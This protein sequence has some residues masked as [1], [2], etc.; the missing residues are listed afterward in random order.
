MIPTTS[1]SKQSGAPMGD[2]HHING[3]SPLAPVASCPASSSGHCVDARP[4]INISISEFSDFW[5]SPQPEGQKSQSGHDHA[6]IRA[7]FGSVRRGV[8]TLQFVQI[9][10]MR[11]RRIVMRNLSERSLRGMLAVLFVVTVGFSIACASAPVPVMQSAS[12]RTFVEPSLQP[13]AV[14]SIAIFPMRNVRLQPD[15][16]REI[17]R[18]I[19]EGFRKQNPQLKIVGATESVTMLNDGGL[20]EKYSE[21]LRNYSQSSIPDV[22]ILQEIGRSLGVNAILQ[23]EVFSV[24][25]MDA[26]SKMYYGKTSLQMRYI[27]LSTSNGSILWDSSSSAFKLSE[28]GQP[29]PAI[30]EVIQMGQEKIL[31]SLPTLAQ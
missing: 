15:E 17:N 16:L 24:N 29:A 26:P 9:T 23:G 21:F 13:G 25:Q 27:L 22:K 30:Y 7:C 8:D 6:S 19:T 5:C 20:A 14:K 18:S 2:I 4:P 1:C 11:Q 3:W 31:N 12:V 10:T 28:P